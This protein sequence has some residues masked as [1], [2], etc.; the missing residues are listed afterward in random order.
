[1]R[2]RALVFDD[3]PMIRTLLW[4]ILDGRGYQVFTFPDPGLCPLYAARECACPTI[5][6]CTDVIISDLQMPNVKGLDF[7]EALRAKG[8]HCSAIALMSGEWSEDDR[9]RGR[10]IGCALFAKPFAIAD[11]AEW[12][13]T[14][15][16]AVKPGRELVDAPRVQS[17]A[18]S[19]AATQ[20]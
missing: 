11:L 16:S 3:D 10:D 15:E 18:R 17:K 6:A 2:L 7:V 13:D 12:L 1:M 19:Q 4:E 5:G 20:P 8:C 9:R 14:V